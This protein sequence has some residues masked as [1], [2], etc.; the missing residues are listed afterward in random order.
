[1]YDQG[2]ITTE[3]VVA[4]WDMG[5]ASDG[6]NPLAEEDGWLRGWVSEA[7]VRGSARLRVWNGR[8]D[9]Y[10]QELRRH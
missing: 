4:T 8:N 6:L 5:A 7:L 2:L 3:V 10:L 9:W 1:M